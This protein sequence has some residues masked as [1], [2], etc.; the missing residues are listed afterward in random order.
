[1]LAALITNLL[2]MK[3]NNGVYAATLSNVPL[4]LGASVTV[5]GAYEAF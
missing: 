5:L 3:I 4:V 2:G 1:L